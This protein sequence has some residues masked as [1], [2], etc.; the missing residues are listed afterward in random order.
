MFFLPKNNFKIIRLVYPIVLGI[1]GVVL[2]ILVSIRFKDFIDYIAINS[3]INWQMLFLILSLVIG[4]FIFQVLSDYMLQILGTEVVYEIRGLLIKKILY[5][6]KRVFDTKNSGD[7]A[8]ILVNDTSAIYHLVSTTIPSLFNSSIAIILI[9]CVLFYLSIKLSITLL[10]VVPLIF[11][12]FIPLGNKLAIISIK[13]QEQIGNLNVFGQYIVSE[14][15]FIKSYVAQSFEEKNGRNIN[16]SIK[17][18]GIYQAKIYAI[19]TPL[20]STIVI[21][22]VL[23]I[24]SYGL[25]LISNKELTIG[26]FI[27]YISLFYQLVS[28]IGELGNAFAQIKGIKGAT[29][30]IEELLSIVNIEDIYIGSRN[31]EFKKISFKN[32]TFSYDTKKT[33]LNKINLSVS[34]GETVAIVGPSGAG[35]TTI[36]SLLERF[37][38]IDSGEIFIDD[39]SIQSISLDYLRSNIGY[40]SQKYPIV[41]GTIRDNLLYGLVNKNISDQHLYNISKFTNFYEVLDRLPDKLDSKVGEKGILLSEGEKQRLVLTRIF[42][43]DPPILLLDEITSSIDSYSEKVV[44]ESIEKINR[45]KL[46]IIVAHRLSTIQNADKIIF[47]ENG[48]ITGVGTH[49]ELLE[50][51][52]L[53]TKF[54]EYQIQK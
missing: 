27:A 49:L 7:I 38:D 16:K 41:T 14:N 52:E 11:L 45:D 12:L 2:A 48:N 9:T 30:R 37:Y 19:I 21:I 33:N 40:V 54:I 35:K 53:Y 42:L 47:I 17:D 50:N 39:E 28:P 4:Q 24:I 10:I 51:H 22:S 34:K 5:L 18:I 26:S 43:I 32:V 46:V 1:I 8:S 44:Q 31:L 23:S 6:P 29:K 3:R 25:Y 15:T 36:I 20:M 13:L